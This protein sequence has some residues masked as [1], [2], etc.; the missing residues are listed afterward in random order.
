MDIIAKTCSTECCGAEGYHG[1]CCRI[2]GR[3][4]IIGPI[5]DSWETLDRLRKGHPWLTWDDCFVSWE[6]GREIYPERSTWQVP[7]S[8]PAMRVRNGACTFYSEELRSCT[9]YEK[10][11]ETCR[12]FTCEHLSK[13]LSGA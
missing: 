3:D 5:H 12:E 2:E 10:R 8:Y 11:P 7:T 4:W 6:E 13:R 9:I 1:S